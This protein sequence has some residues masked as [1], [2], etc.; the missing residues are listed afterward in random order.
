MYAEPR[1]SLNREMELGSHSELDSPLFQV[2][3]AGSPDTVF[4]DH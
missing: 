4:V 3:A 2:S 1:S